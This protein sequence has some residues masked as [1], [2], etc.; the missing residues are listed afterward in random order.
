MRD[1]DD[2]R[3]PTPVL[4]ADQ[5]A[6]DAIAR[7]ESRA[8]TNTVPNR[9][10]RRQ[11]ETVKQSKKKWAETVGDRNPIR[12]KKVLLSTLAVGI[13]GLIALALMTQYYFQENFWL[14]WSRM[15]LPKYESALKKYPSMAWMLNP[16]RP[17]FAD[18]PRADF[19]PTG[20]SARTDILPLPDLRQ[21]SP[22]S[23]PF[24]TVPV[25]SSVELI[26][27]M[28]SAQPGD[29]IELQPGTYYFDKAPN[30]LVAG[31]S[32]R[33]ITVGARHRGDAKL[34]FDTVEGFAV[35]APYW[36]FENL[37]ING[38]CKS[39]SDCEHAFHV[40]GAGAHVTIRNNTVRN[41]NAHIKANADLTTMLVPDDGLVE[42]NRFFN[43]HARV[44]DNPVTP[45]NLDTVSRWRVRGNVISDFAKD[46]QINRT[47]YGAFMKMYGSDGIF[48]N[49]L[50]SCEWLFR[51]G[52]RIG[53]SFGG[54][55]PDLFKGQGGNALVCDIVECDNYHDRGIM[56]DNLIMNC[57]ND[58]AIY[59]NKSRETL[60]QNNRLKRT[61][62]IDVRFAESSAKIV[63]NEFDGR[64]MVRDHAQ[65][66][67]RENKSSK[68]RAVFL[69]PMPTSPND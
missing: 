17:V 44:T 55:G 16:L 25:R 38:I 10:M 8:K 28:Q 65:V 14:T 35:R 64:I 56:R 3:K 31:T 69:I 68:W 22:I 6:L 45:V 21:K 61:R 9:E 30:A 49:N 27:V 18:D 7:F 11:P 60:I 40:V 1:E 42:S 51:G 34:E 33:P 2:E 26:S 13:A 24:R 67:I 66:E 53:L 41:F 57:P 36:I 29:Y 4:K 48:E 20:R 62:G 39:D 59:I 19:V 37:D 15:L 63:E 5:R 43:D 58:V 46:G 32:G 47:S 54:G 23:V 12:L 50:V 52:E